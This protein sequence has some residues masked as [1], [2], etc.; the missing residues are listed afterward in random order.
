MSDEN[1]GLQFLD[2]FYPLLQYTNLSESFFCQNEDA[3]NVH[4]DPI[5]SNSISPIIH[6]FV[7]FFYKYVWNYLQICE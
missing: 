6:I 5:L 3:Q 1:T 4:L 2:V 7:R